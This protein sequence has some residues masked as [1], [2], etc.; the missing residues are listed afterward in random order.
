[1]VKILKSLS[2]LRTNID[3]LIL[4]NSKPTRS[5]N[6]QETS[7]EEGLEVSPSAMINSQEEIENRI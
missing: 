6:V 2:T 7:D 3:Q 5:Y 1:M 4:L